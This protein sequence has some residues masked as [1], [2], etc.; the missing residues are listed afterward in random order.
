MP[1]LEKMQQVHVLQELQDQG[2]NIE[3]LRAALAAKGPPL[4]LAQTRLAMR[5]QRLSRYVLG[6]GWGG[7]DS[8]P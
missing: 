2:R 6:G 7:R 8:L 1:R 5:T 3:E 4:K